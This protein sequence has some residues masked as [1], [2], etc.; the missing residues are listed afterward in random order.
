M[1]DSPRIGIVICTYN[2]R[3][4][5]LACLDSVERQDYPAGRLGV[6]V[7]DDGSTDGT[8]EAAAAR[9]RAMTDAGLGRA[10]LI[11]SLAKPGIAQ[12]RNEAARKA[13]EASDLLLF[14]D[15]DVRP[16]PGCI[17]GLAARMKGHPEVGIVAPSVLRSDDGRTL[18]GPYL[19]HPL[20]FTYKVKESLGET[21]C[22]WVDPACIMV[23]PGVFSATGGFWP[24]Y[25]RSHEG[26]DLCLRAGKAGFK[27]LYYPAVRAVHVMRPEKLSSER[28]YYLYRNKF[29]VI[30]RNGSL[31]QRLFLLPLLAAAALPKYLLE[32]LTRNRAPGEFSAITAAVLDGLSGKEGA[33]GT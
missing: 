19:V 28:L 12:G 6:W 16:E 8:S 29:T 3:E 4:T 11:T 22:D 17:G 1:T 18:H 15:D 31:F 30:R 2:R 5:L 9:L 25:Y 7:Y 20:T 24:G 21:F 32:S 27:V 23:S 26:V 13:L 33:R 14:L 10:E